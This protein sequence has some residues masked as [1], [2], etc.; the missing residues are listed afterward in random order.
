MQEVNNYNGS[1]LGEN[2]RNFG[3]HNWVNIN[4]L[5]GSRGHCWTHGY[6]VS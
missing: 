5:L 3:E 1:G 4:H 6:I 2:Q